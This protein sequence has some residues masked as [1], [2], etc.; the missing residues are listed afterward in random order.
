MKFAFQEL[1]KLPALSWLAEFRKGE[2]NVRVLH[3]KSVETRDQFFVA[4]AWAGAFD[5][6]RFSESVF[7]CCTGGS[8]TKWG[9]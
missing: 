1:E 5:E 7:C 8:R 4:G 9:G 2:E 6:G 3:G